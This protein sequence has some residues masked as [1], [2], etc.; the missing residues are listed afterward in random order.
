MSRA[1]AGDGLNEAVRIFPA[2]LK[3]PLRQRLTPY[4]IWGGFACFTVYCLAALD[5]FNFS[6]LAA[7][8]KKLF[9]VVAFMLPPAAHG[10]L[11]DFT[12]A[13]FETLGIV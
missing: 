5:F 1:M 3:R 7:G 11:Q 8:L 4:L 2:A 12:L 10:R 9:G 6:M 13:I